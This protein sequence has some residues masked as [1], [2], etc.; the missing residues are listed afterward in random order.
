MDSQDP[1]V[2]AFNL[3]IIAGR[4]HGSRHQDGRYADMTDER[5]IGLTLSI[6]G[7][8]IFIIGVMSSDSFADQLNL[9]VTGR[10]T[11]VTVWYMIGGIAF[12]VVGGMMVGIGGSQ[13]YK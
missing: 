13:R 7:I 3:M 4:R 9:F 8:A 12:L 1:S 10:F 11:D 2:L 6:G 5:L